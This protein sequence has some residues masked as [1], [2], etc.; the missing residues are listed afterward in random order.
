MSAD[1]LMSEAAEGEGRPES[2]ALAVGDVER[3]V[4]RLLT[5]APL[6]QAARAGG[7]APE[8][9]AEAAEIYQRSGRQ[10]LR[11]RHTT[12]WLQL[13]IEFTDWTTAEQTAADHIALLLEEARDSGVVSAWWFM[14][15]FPCWRFRLR[16]GPTGTAMKSRLAPAFDELVRSGRIGR[17]WPGAY[18][19]ETA[20]FGGR[21][22][23]DLAHD[24]FCADSDAI[25]RLARN[26]AAG[27]GRRELSLF[28]CTTLL[29]AAGLE[30]YERGDVWHRV[31]LERSLPTDVSTSKLT[32]MANDL[33]RLM[34][35]D[36]S[37]AGP[38]LS[39][40]GPLASAAGWAD[41]FRRAGHT[42]GAAARGGTLERGLRDVASY[43]TIFHWN[44]IGL[45]TRAQSM[46]AWSARAAIL[47]PPPTGQT[48]RGPTPCPGLR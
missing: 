30:W 43:L 26:G 22:G 25:A 34:V 45:S 11:A 40:G 12:D 23:M 24:L 46:L 4:L 10:A 16:P 1:L 18:E 5:G 6:S 47:G 27:L 21:A 29:R 20:A 9:L 37:P 13:Y 44:R 39:A 35:V 3:A 28:L 7:L 31:C 8:D 41:A 14:R 36:T 48:E 38:L 15:K 33:R 2:T 42:L 19:A 17:W 32:A